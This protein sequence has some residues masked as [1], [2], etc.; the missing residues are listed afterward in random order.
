MGK[1]HRKLE[2]RFFT[3]EFFAAMEA[4][5]E[6]K[7]PKMVAESRIKLEKTAAVLADPIELEKAGGSKI[8]KEIQGIYIAKG[9]NAE[10][11][12]KFADEF[13]DELILA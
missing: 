9:K 10:L 7:Y 3:R 13:Q 11:L 8:V 5:S 4:F 2:K 6:N 1:E 12:R